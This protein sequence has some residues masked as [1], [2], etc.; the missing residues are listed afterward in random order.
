MENTVSLACQVCTNIR[1][2]KEMS[3]QTLASIWKKEVLFHEN[4]HQKYILG[5]FEA[6]YP[7]SIKK[8]M[9]E[10]SITHQ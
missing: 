10:Q 2:K 6:F 7:F 3:Y 8:F 4:V 9:K 5:F 1:C